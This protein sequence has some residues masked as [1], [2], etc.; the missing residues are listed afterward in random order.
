MSGGEA[1]PFQ[2]G[3]GGCSDASAADFGQAGNGVFA[4][5]HGALRSHPDH[6]ATAYNYARRL[7]TLKG[8]TPY[9]FIC[10]A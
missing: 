9:A 10:K 7:K 4:L 3:D 5:K 8:L 6:F 2:P 1:L